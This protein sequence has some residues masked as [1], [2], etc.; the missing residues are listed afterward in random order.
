MTTDIFCFSTLEIAYTD[1][2]K[3]TANKQW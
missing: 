2:N 3:V 1:Q